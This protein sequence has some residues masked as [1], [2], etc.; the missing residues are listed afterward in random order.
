MATAGGRIASPDK[1][2]KIVSQNHCSPSDGVAAQFA[3]GESL[4]NVM[5]LKASGRSGLCNAVVRNAVVRAQFCCA[6]GQTLRC[7]DFAAAAHAATFV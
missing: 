4:S 6:H 5:W 2:N 1:L 7:G 3:A